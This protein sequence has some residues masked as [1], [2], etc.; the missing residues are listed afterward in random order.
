MI[1]PNRR[2]FL[3]TVTVSGVGLAMP[4]YFLSSA[5]AQ[6]SPSPSDRLRLG[7]IACGDMAC[8]NARDFDPF[9]DFAAMSDVNSDQIAYAMKD[10]KIGK[11]GTAEERKI[12][13]YK[14]Y[15]RILDRKDIDIVSIAT[16]DHWHVKQA[17]EA[18]QAGKHVFCE[19]PLTLTLEE[20]QLIRK[21]CE[22][23]DR[24]F[25]VGTRLRSDQPD[26]VVFVAMAQKGLIGEI[27]KATVCV[28]GGPHSPALPTVPVPEIL[29]YE[30]WIGPAPMVPYRASEARMDF[31]ERKDV[32]PRQSN[33]FYNFRW[34][35]DYSGGKLTDIGAHQVDMAL[36][37]LGR[38]GNG[39][40]PVKITPHDIEMPVRME[41]GYPVETNRYNTPSQFRIECTYEDGFILE[42]VSK[43]PDG[44]GVLLEGSKGRLHY[45]GGRI[46][47]KPYEI[48]KV[49]ETLTGDDFRKLRKGKEWMSHKANFIACIRDGGEP[50]SDAFSHVQAMAVCHLCVLAARLGREIVW[51]PKKEKL[52]DEQAQSF[53]ARTP[54]RGFEIPKV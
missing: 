29:D 21:A 51:D 53:F 52:G 32:W 13:T 37:A 25:Q 6:K 26:A 23:Y 36:W 7:M 5:Q 8:R 28:G 14:E 22:K 1:R 33:V 39:M 19:K 47:G 40:G 38:N 34:W 11:A 48:D 46:K 12:D 43:S 50:V 49:Q 17:I 2:D 31:R 4:P 27:K 3:K 9:V 45:N 54:R 44:A 18:L 30:L 42:V 16:P 15:Q 41:S 35:L 24:K 20:N 10:A